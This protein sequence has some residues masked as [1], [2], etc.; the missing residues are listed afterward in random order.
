[1]VLVVGAPARLSSG[2]HIG[3]FILYPDGRVALYAK[4]HLGGDEG[5]VFQPSNRNPLVELP[6]ATAAVAICADTGFASHAQDAAERG[7]TVYLAS[8]VYSPAEFGVLTT[9]LAS[10]ARTHG[11]TVALANAGGHASTMESAGGSSV[12]SACGDL[13]ARHDGLG[14]GV[15][16]AE[17]LGERW[18]GRVVV[19]DAD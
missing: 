2:L 17:K 3:A 6:D 10:Y 18:I 19:G 9:K 1:M 8:V 5:E 14:S 11:M 13:L 4:H 16:I 12:W 15:A 7:A